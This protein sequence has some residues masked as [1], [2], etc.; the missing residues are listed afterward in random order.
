MFIEPAKGKKRGGFTLLEISFAVAIL[1]M[2]SMA[3]YRF[4]QSNLTSMRVSWDEMAV[5]ASYDGMHNLLSLEWQDLP[6]GDGRLTGEPF[7]FEGRS[8]DQVNWVCG[9][10]AGLLTRYAK[11]EY[12]ATLRMRPSNKHRNQHD[13]GLIRKSLD[14]DSD[15]D[16]TWVPLLQN[17]KSLEIR[18]FDPRLNSWVDRWTDTSTLPRLVRLTI[19]RP[20]SP[21]PW[22]TIVALGRT[23]L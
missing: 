2:M 11:G 6:G 18:Y 9:S 14:S 23:P 17:V 5:D 7:K 19:D 10:G 1:A 21:V 3:I 20:D 13:I 15:D 12:L 16:V 8:Q 22:E 4:V